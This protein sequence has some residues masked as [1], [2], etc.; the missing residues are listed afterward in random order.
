MVKNRIKEILKMRGMTQTDLAKKM[1]TS[2]ET[3]SRQIN[4]NPTLKTLSD[5]AAA[6]EVPV[7]ELFTMTTDGND[8]YGFIEYRGEVYKIASIKD[9]ERLLTKV[10]E[11][12]RDEQI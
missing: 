8:L 9:L 1:G 12:L 10:V 2:Q 5:M 7:R 11:G 6:L 3:V 4:G